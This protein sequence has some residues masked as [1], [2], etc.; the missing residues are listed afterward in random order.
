MVTTF[1]TAGNGGGHAFR[2]DRDGVLEDVT[3][4]LGI[5]DFSGATVSAVTPLDA[6]N[7]GDQDLFFTLSGR[8][9][10]GVRQA[11]GRTWFKFTSSRDLEAGLSLRALGRITMTLMA[12]GY[13]RH[14]WGRFGNG[15]TIGGYPVKL[16]VD[17]GR[18]APAAGEPDLA[19][20]G[21]TLW[22]DGDGLLRLDFR[23]DRARLQAATGWLETASGAMEITDSYGLTDDPPGKADRLFLYD[24]GSFRDV[25]ADSGLRDAAAGQEAVS[26]DFDNDGDLDLYV[27]NGRDIFGNPPNALYENLGGAR[28]RNVAET[29]GALGSTSGRG[30]SVTEFDYDRDGDLD[31]L[32]TNGA[33][34]APGN[35]GPVQLLRNDTVGGT[36]CR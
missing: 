30:A 5:D 22:R 11:D 16:G 18:L 1:L 21:I 23:A 4:A 33:G 7:D 28:F 26:G 3:G 34:P 2:P 19:T 10:Q 15:E 24:E 6:D 17:D 9:N 36:G 8:V 25:T 14:Q 27:V 29:A 35:N 31:L 32:I 13:R 12:E 20:P